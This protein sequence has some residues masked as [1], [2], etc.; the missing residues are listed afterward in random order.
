MYRK[1]SLNKEYLISKDTVV[2]ASSNRKLPVIDGK[3]SIE[4][5]NRK[6]GTY[7]IY[8]LYMLS[9][10]KVEPHPAIMESLKNITFE[11]IDPIPSYFKYLD[12]VDGKVMKFSRPIYYKDGFRYVPG[13]TFLAINEEGIV[14]STET[15]KIIPVDNNPQ[16]YLICNVNGSSYMHHRLVALAWIRNPSIPKYQI[17]NHKNGDKSDNR[18]CNLEWTDL[19]GN[20]RHAQAAGLNPQTIKVRMRNFHTKEVIEVYGLSEAAR[21]CGVSTAQR[22]WAIQNRNPSRLFG[23]W[24]IKLEG[25][26]SPWF[27]ENRDKIAKHGRYHIEVTEEDGTIKEFRDIR[28]FVKEYKLWNLSST[29]YTLA[30]ILKER[31]PGI[32]VRITKKGTERAIV[33]LNIDTGDKNTYPSVK[34]ASRDIG[35]SC[36]AIT[37]ACLSNNNKVITNGATGKQW[38]CKYLDMDDGNWEPNWDA[39]RRTVSF[40]MRNEKTGEVKV[41][42]S[43]RGAARDL[44]ICRSIIKT[45]LKTG[46]PYN[47]WIFKEIME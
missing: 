11:E 1:L 20:V 8:W 3:V 28:D 43:L 16:G 18:I 39:V 7:D 34:S 13:H 17:V 47:G 27:Y 33:I 30:T 5:G 6:L 14:V 32:K 4:L 25:D 24:E 21:I 38:I 36:G 35:L 15:G 23:E 10:Y 41:F 44:N 22:L 12:V 26:N 9:S 29:V 46:K 40:E 2:E 45:R 37:N 42:N 19:S 31:R